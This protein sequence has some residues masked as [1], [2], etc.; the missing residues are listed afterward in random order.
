MIARLWRGAVAARDGEEYL[1]LM[2]EVAVPDYRAIPGNL[3]AWCLN[4]QR[5]RIVE[6]MMLTFWE[7]LE[8]IGAFA[9]DEL[10]KA[11]YY[12]FDDGY[13]LW[14]EQEVEHFDIAAGEADKRLSEVCFG[15]PR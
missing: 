6:V 8:A 4:K 13:L 3:G 9:G 10:T 7:D 1:R 5:G 12:E 14:R 11:K 2:R 15:L